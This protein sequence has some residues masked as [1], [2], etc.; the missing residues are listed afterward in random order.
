MRILVVGAGAIGGYIGARLLAAGRDATFLVR[1]ARAA[2]LA[3]TGLVLRSLRG[4]VHHPAPPT[5]TADR[6][7]GAFDLVVL[8]CKSYDLDAAMADVAPAVGPD[9][10]V[11]P[12][13]NGLRHLEALDARF[14]ETRV[15]GGLCVLPTTLDE[16]GRVIHL[17]DTHSTV[18]GERRG[19]RSARVEAIEAAFAGVDCGP[20]LSPDVMQ[21]MWDKW[22]FLAASASL[23]CLMRAAVGD[24]VEAG[25]AD[26]A[27]AILAECAAIA[28]AAGLRPTEASMA[29]NRAVLTEA[30]SP[31]TTSMLRDVE[32]GS[33][34]EAD[35]VVGDLLRRGAA[36]GVAAPVLR[37]VDAQLRAY[38]ARRVRE[39]RP[40]TA[41]GVR[42][43]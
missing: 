35:H 24:V 26:L 14:G 16:A 17:G 33:R 8:A 2:V 3:R 6:L 15:L 41:E 39:Q 38:E 20:R 31:R 29:R 25:A 28:E 1:P 18:F 12:L 5:L 34:T 40:A 21:D 11:L 30:G 42:G 22:V 37:I 32:R 10:A 9:T 27:L 7:A 23:N 43:W 36:A 19:G 4:D 13:L